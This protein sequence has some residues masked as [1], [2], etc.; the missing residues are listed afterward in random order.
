MSR[1]GEEMGRLNLTKDPA[2][3]NTRHLNFGIF[4]EPS[5]ITFP[6]TVREISKS[7]ELN[8][9]SVKPRNTN[10]MRQLDFDAMRIDLILKRLEEIAKRIAEIEESQTMLLVH[11]EELEKSMSEHASD[12]LFNV[13]ETCKL[14]GVTRAYLYKLVQAKAVPYHR[15]NGKCLYFVQSE[16]LDWVKNGCKCDRNDI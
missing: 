4:S 2:S 12:K 15:P 14:L 9:F 10:L 11:L 3:W 8:L 16:L 13:K 5:K 6:L 1:D 7:P